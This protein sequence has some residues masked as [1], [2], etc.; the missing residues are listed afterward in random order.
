LGTEVL[1]NHK[2]YLERI[3]SYKNFGYDVE[4][5]RNFIL[6][7]SKPIEGDILEIGTGKGHFTLALAKKGYNF[8][9]VDISVKEQE[10]ARLNIKYLKLD[11]QV[12]FR[13]DDAEDLSFKNESFDVVFAIN[14]IHHFKNPF[15]AI[16]EFKRVVKPKGKI[17]LSDFNEEGFKMMDKIHAVKG[18]K[19]EAG[20]VTLDE[21]SD[22]LENKGFSIRKHQREIQDIVVVHN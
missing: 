8:T 5:E 3:N 4:R 20:K 22:Y 21:I 12:K 10:F 7:K 2:R 1:E 19:H 14:V 13:I 18:R 9:S 16:N 11:K 6:E 15:K 17:I